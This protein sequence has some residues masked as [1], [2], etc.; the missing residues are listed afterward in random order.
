VTFQGSKL[1]DF[2]KRKD[3]EQRLWTE[4]KEKTAYSR[5]YRKHTTYKSCPSNSSSI[6]QVGLFVIF[7]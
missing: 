5:T 6:L 2:W 1:P 7:F 4:R 3:A